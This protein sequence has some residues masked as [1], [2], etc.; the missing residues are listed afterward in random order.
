MTDDQE[1]ALIARATGIIIRALAPVS[2]CVP[3][4]DLIRRQLAAAA[5]AAA[6]PSDPPPMP[7]AERKAHL[8]S[9]ARQ[10]GAL[11]RLLK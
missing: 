3:C 10:F 9:A 4:E 1:I 11:G 6:P 8:A 7:E 5:E 2:A